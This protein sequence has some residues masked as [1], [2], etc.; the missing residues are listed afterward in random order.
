MFGDII[1]LGGDDTKISIPEFSLGSVGTDLNRRGVEGGGSAPNENGIEVEA[2]EGANTL[3]PLDEADLLATAADGVPRRL[4]C[5]LPLLLRLA[6]WWDRN[7]VIFK[8][9]NKE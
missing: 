2:G 4:C 6:K 7:T 9:V 1:S 3:E 8:I 5:S